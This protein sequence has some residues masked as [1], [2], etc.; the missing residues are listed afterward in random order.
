VLGAYWLW[1][2]AIGFWLFVMDIYTRVIMAMNIGYWAMIID[3]W[4]MVMVIVCG[5]DYCL[6]PLAI[7]YCY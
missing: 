7:S 2:L 5:Y 3:Y 6:W 1:L 4:A